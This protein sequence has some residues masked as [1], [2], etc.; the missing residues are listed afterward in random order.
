MD[1]AFPR[2]GRSSWLLLLIELPEATKWC[3]TWRINEPLPSL[4]YLLAQK[5]A[6]ASSNS[7]VALVA[8]INNPALH[9]Q[10]FTAESQPLQDIDFIAFIDF[11]A[12]AIMAISF[13]SSTCKKVLSFILHFCFLLVRLYFCTVGR[14]I[15]SLSTSSQPALLC[16]YCIDV[17]VWLEKKNRA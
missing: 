3:R 6:G 15:W 10:L 11:I 8:Q 5:S 14:V 13:C 12:K 16:L 17:S 9:I 7:A 1:G 4:S 2:K